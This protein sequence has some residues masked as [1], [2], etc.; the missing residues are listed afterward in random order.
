MGE[1]VRFK[2][3]D[4]IGMTK[5]RQKKRFFE[6]IQATIEREHFECLQSHKAVPRQVDIA[7]GSTA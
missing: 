1:F 4:N 3:S 2:H 6:G 7:K 5:L